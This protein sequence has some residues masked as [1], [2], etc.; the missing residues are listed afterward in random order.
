MQQAENKF[1]DNTWADLDSEIGFEKNPTN[2]ESSPNDKLDEIDALISGHQEV[3]DSEDTADAE[4]DQGED[5]EVISEDDRADDDDDQTDGEDSDEQA[6]VESVHD[7]KPRLDYSLEIEVPMPYGMEKMTVG[8]MKDIV[9]DITRR[10]KQIEDSL[11]L[12]NQRERQLV[13]LANIFQ[14]QVTPEVRAKLDEY[15]QLRLQQEGYLMMR[16]IPEWEDN[17]VYLKDQNDMRRLA[18]Q[19]GFSNEEFDGVRDHRQVMLARKAVL[20]EREI[21]T[22][23]KKLSQFAKQE[24]STKK[25]QRKTARKAIQQNTRAKIDQ[26]VQKGRESK[27]P[28]DKQAAISEL[29]KNM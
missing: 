24:N 14:G 21:A 6:D 22:L 3:T 15:D 25:P 20:Q 7:E 2:L 17:S 1:N 5:Q 9:V 16:S 29:L 11:S 19:L 26:I 27:T 8:Q 13:D 23:K 10:E 28:Q 4:S 12:T 18:N